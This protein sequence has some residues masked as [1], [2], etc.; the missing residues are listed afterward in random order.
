VIHSGLIGS[1]AGRCIVSGDDTTGLE[2][3]VNFPGLPV[4]EIPFTRSPGVSTPGG[5]PPGNLY[6]FN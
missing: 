2:P 6:V 3:E 4:T 1:E 5:I